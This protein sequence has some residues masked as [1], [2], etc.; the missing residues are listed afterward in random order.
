MGR[1][2]RPND[3]MSN[4]PSLAL[5]LVVDFSLPDVFWK[6]NT[7][8]RKQSR[9]FLDC[10]EDNF[11]TQQV[12]APAREAAPLDLL[13]VNLGGGMTVIYFQKKNGAIA[14]LI[15]SSAT[16]PDHYDLSKMIMSSLIV[17]FASSLS[18]GGCIP[19]GLMDSCLSSLGVL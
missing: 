13:F 4:S 12:S 5:V 18:T 1:S 7:A 11:L 19:S 16:S 9:R 17:V 15:L 3:P 14:S 10:V 2:C 6:C 8:E